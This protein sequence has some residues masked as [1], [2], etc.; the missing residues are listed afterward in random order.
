MPQDIIAKI[1]QIK[2]VLPKKQRQLCGYLAMNYEQVGVMTVSELAQAAGVGTTTVMRLVQTLEMP[3]F[4]AFKK[5]LLKAALMRNSSFHPG[6]KGSLSGPAA[7]Q[8]ALRNAVLDGVGV[9]EN[10]CTPTNEKQFDAV[11]EMLLRA[12]RI[13]TFGLRTSK[14]MALYFESLADLF[15]PH[16]TQLSHDPEFIFDRLSLYVKPADVVLFFSAWP[17]TK[18]TIEAAEFCRDQGIPIALITNTGLNPIAK[19]AD[20]VIDTNSVNH[21]SGNM[22]FM[23]VIEALISEIGRKTAPASAA[24]MEQVEAILREKQIILQEY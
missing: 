21:A 10:L 14:H 22:A 17:C 16:V 19:F 15:Y 24:N 13:F 7:D 2:D 23:I 12:D 1:Q 3:S 9:L 20:A 5:E 4:N 18:R 6:L 8:H 11:I